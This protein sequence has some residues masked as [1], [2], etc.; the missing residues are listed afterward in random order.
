MFTLLNFLMESS[1][2]NDIF[3][4]LRAVDFIVFQKYIF[5]LAQK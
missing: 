3:R 5:Q 1:H 4:I 2:T